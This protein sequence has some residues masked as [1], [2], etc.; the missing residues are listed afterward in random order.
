MLMRYTP[1][2]IRR[3]AE[4]CELSEKQNKIHWKITSG[5]ISIKKNGE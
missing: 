2:T 3:L 5:K 1:E 4:G